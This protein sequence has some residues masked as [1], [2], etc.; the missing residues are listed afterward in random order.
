MFSTESR[1][2]RKAERLDPDG[3]IDEKQ[4]A[5][6]GWGVG[7]RAFIRSHSLSTQTNLS[8]SLTMLVIECMELRASVCCCFYYCLGL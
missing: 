3:H 2:L 1:F 8:T 4:G 5:G 6:W 7:E